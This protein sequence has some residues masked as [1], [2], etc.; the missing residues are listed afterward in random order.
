MIQKKI[1]EAQVPDYAP[2]SWGGFGATMF[3]MAMFVTIIF[4]LVCAFILPVPLCSASI[5]WKLLS[6]VCLISMLYI[7]FG[8]PLSFWKEYY[9]RNIRGYILVIGR[10]HDLSGEVF[11][12][13]TSRQLKP[14]IGKIN[15]Q[16]RCYITVRL[17]GWF[18]NQ[19]LNF[20]QPSNDGLFEILF[21]PAK[22]TFRYVDKVKSSIEAPEGWLIEIRDGEGNR[23]VCD[24]RKAF[25]L[26][27]EIRFSPKEFDNGQSPHVLFD[28]L[29]N[30]IKRSVLLAS[31]DKENRNLANDFTEKTAR[32]RQNLLGLLV[33]CV[34]GIDGTKRFIQSKEAQKL[35]ESL[36][37][38]YL[39][40]MTWLPDWDQRRQKLEKS[41]KHPGRAG[42]SQPGP[43][44][45]EKDDPA[46]A[47]EV[48]PGCTL[49]GTSCQSAALTPTAAGLLPV[50]RYCP[51]CS[52]YIP[53]GLPHCPVCLKKLQSLV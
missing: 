30:F 10:N 34:D 1:S 33:D 43:K 47:E 48:C 19:R 21:A 53:A 15:S 49:C 4:W 45:N 46:E 16:K 37:K 24:W 41:L 8:Q 27:R 17:G 6:G 3:A 7:L 40:Q 2:I 51:H 32:L 39:P 44:P 31:A 9:R 38:K 52:E 42:R 23:I 26:L 29:T 18:D 28:V 36:L 13:T 5:G 22:L 14:K 35:K 12:L 20:C 25:V 11:Y 50:F